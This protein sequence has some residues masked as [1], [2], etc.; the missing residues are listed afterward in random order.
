MI[1]LDTH[2][3]AWFHLAA[4]KLGRAAQSTITKALAEQKLYVCTLSFFELGRKATRGQIKGLSNLESFRQTL[5]SNGVRE[6]VPDGPSVV[7]SVDLINAFPDAMDA[8]FVATADVHMLT[9]L[10][11]DDRILAWRGRVKRIDARK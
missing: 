3:V 5:L 4:D 10:T 9:L 7:R 1:L 11:A 8:L 2:C 6:I